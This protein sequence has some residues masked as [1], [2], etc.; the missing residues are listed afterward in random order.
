MVIGHL[1]QHQT[2]ILL[3]DNFS[4]FRLDSPACPTPGISHAL[5]IASDPHSRIQYLMLSPVEP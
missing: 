1:S 4:K 5:V 2:Q 3:D